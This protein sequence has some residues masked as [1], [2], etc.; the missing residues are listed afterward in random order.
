MRLIGARAFFSDQTLY[1][2]GMGDDVNSG[3]LFIFVIICATV[4]IALEQSRQST[5]S[6]TVAQQIQ[7]LYISE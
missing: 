3:L 2:S 1:N 5:L 4:A 7:Y 6:P